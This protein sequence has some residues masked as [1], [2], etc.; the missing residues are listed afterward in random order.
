MARSQDRARAREN[1]EAAGN[2]LKSTSVTD[3]FAPRTAHLSVTR[4]ELGSI[5]SQYH[6]SLRAKVWY[7][8]LW[9]WIVNRGRK[10]GATIAD[11]FL[12]LRQQD[13]LAKA[14]A[15]G[16]AAKEKAIREAQEKLRANVKRVDATGKVVEPEETVGDVQKS[17]IVI[18]R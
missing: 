1:E 5:F 12:Y 7:R 8:R 10:P 3:Y 17:D 11:Y 6:A 13:L 9:F 18:A 15:D 16:M 2:K 4:G 14:F